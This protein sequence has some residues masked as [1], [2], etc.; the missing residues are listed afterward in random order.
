[1][2]GSALGAGCGGGS[3]ALGTGAIAS[4]GTNGGLNF[5][6]RDVSSGNISGLSGDSA[7]SA[8]TNRGSSSGG[9]SSNTSSESTSVVT[10]SASGALV[11]IGTNP[12]LGAGGVASSAGRGGFDGVW[13]GTIERSG[14]AGSSSLSG[15]G[16]AS[17]ADTGADTGDAQ[18]VSGLAVVAESGRGIGSVLL[19]DVAVVGGHRAGDGVTR[20]GEDWGGNCCEG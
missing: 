7:S 15:A 8:G 17:G 19:A 1:M 4:S 3:S 10:G 18:V 20:S 6:C 11:G 2:A 14:G 12:A 9:T 16:W 5:N 13:T